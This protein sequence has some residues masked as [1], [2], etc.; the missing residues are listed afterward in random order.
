MFSRAIAIIMVAIIASFITTF[1]W[2]NAQVLILI[3][4]MAALAAIVLGEA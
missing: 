4:A 2:E 3:P 1:G